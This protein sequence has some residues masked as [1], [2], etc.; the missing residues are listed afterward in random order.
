MQD[1]RVVLLQ[2]GRSTTSDC[3]KKNYYQTGG[4]PLLRSHTS[5]KAEKKEP[6]FCRALLFSSLLHT[7]SDVAGKGCSGASLGRVPRLTQTE[8]VVMATAAGAAVAQAR[9]TGPE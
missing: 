5:F 6:G 1:E 3:K 2:V 4:L 8:V 7:L 9:G